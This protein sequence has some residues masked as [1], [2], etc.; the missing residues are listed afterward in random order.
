MFKEY[1]T[2][3]NIQFFDTSGRVIDHNI[4][5]Y[6]EDDAIGVNIWDDDDC[7]ASLLRDSDDWIVERVNPFYS[8]NDESLESDTY[9]DVM[10]FVGRLEKVVEAV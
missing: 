10:E 8:I 7:V 2:D 3:F 6:A 9:S 1:N 5:Y 4:N